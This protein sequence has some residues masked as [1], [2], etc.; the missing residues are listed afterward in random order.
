VDLPVVLFALHLE[1]AEITDAI[2]V[3]LRLAT[4]T[5]TTIPTMLSRRM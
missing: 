4:T 1:A 3:P 2:H 5:T